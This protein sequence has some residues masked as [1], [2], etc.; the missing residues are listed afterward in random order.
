MVATA[1]R[2][3][4]A[5]RYVLMALAVAAALAYGYHSVAEH[6]REQG[7]EEQRPHILALEASIATT[8]KRASD[9]ALLW[10]T[11]VDKTE[12]VA[13]QTENNRAQTFA[14]LLQE[15]RASGFA[16]GVRYSDAELRLYRRAYLAAR[17]A[18]AESAP[19][20]AETPAAST[21]T[22]EFVVSLYAWIGECKS[23]VS[24]WSEFYRGLQAGTEQTA[25]SPP[26]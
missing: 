10:A 23:R 9:L 1:L 6:F 13:R 16:T 15:A 5:F 24:E 8:Q 12:S 7:R 20:P 2:I 14:K 4:W 25:S 17:G 26:R 11:Q 19:K 3:L 22:A 21:G 18:L